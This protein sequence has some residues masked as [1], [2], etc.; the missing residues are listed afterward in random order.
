MVNKSNTKNK[1]NATV[2]KNKQEK[3][4]IIEVGSSESQDMSISQKLDILMNS[5]QEIGSKI[6]DQDERLRR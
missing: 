6:K 1:S 5:V 3:P 2:D 4:V